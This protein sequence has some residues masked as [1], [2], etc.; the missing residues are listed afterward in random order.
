MSPL[1]LFIYKI[2]SSSNKKL[3]IH[4]ETRIFKENK[5]QRDFIIAKQDMHKIFLKNTAH[6]RKDILDYESPRYNIY[7]IKAID[8]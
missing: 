1:R 8:H 5:K 2:L 3:K 7:L 6:R 4:G